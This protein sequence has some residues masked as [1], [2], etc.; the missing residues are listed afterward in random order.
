[1]DRKEIFRLAAAFVENPQSNAVSPDQALRLEFAGMRLFDEPILAVASAGDPLFAELRAPHIIGPHFCPPEFWLPGARSVLSFFLPLTERIIAA[2]RTDPGWPALEWLHGRIEGQAFQNKLAAH[3][4][5]SLRQAGHAAVIPFQDPRY[6]QRAMPAAQAEDGSAL[7]GFTSNWSERH[8]AYVAGLGT[9]S[10]CA[11]IITKK[12]MAGRLISLI[13]DLPLEPDKRPYSAYDE[14]CAR[15]DACA[16]RCPADA[17]SLEKG[18]EHPPCSAFL[19]RTREKHAPRYGCGKCQTAV[20]CER[21]IP[22]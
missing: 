22:R 15:C 12:G 5:E 17:I 4:A 20:P 3:L 18:K 2:N 7:P 13:T 16:R 14:Y 1:M 8:V 11:G 19:D 6:R 10:L 21:G 9:L